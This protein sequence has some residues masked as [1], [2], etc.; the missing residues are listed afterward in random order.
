MKFNFKTSTEV[1]DYVSVNSSHSPDA[2]AS[3]MIEAY[4]EDMDG[5]PLDTKELNE[6]LEDELTE[7]EDGYKEFIDNH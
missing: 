6:W 3:S 1:Y 2:W 4:I 7:I 5:E